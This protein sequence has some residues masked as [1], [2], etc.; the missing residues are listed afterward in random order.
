MYISVVIPLYNKK[1]AIKDALDSVFNQTFLPDE[2]VI[3]NDGSTDGSEKIVELLNHPLVTLIHQKNAGVSAARNKGI[4]TAKNEWIAFLDADD[5]WM[6]NY[7]KEITDLLPSFPES[8]VLAT[9][10]AL[11]DSSGNR[12]PIILNK[13]PFEGQRGVLTN[14]FQVAAC[15][16][17]PLWSSAIV[18][19]KSA[20]QAVGGFP[21]GIKSGE[22][23]LTWARLAV[24]FQIG[25][26]L[27]VNSVFIQDPAHTYDDKPNRIPEVE[28]I[29]G[30]ELIKLYHLN[31][32]AYFL[33]KYISFWKKMRSSIYLRLGE[34]KRAFTESL[35]AL[36][37]NPFNK[38]VYVYVVMTI[39]PM[40]IVHSIFKKYGG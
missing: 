30:D 24:K 19:K 18:V 34:R 23:L 29:V 17:P 8:S 11:Q 37:Y 38:V 20:L 32:N 13:L 27:S 33:K 21:V 15:S 2:I 5:V 22:D 3:I 25:Y 7:L 36:F 26:S 12:S 28:D 40:K 4:N 1:N 10:Y 35:K 9:A 39:L 31:P 14:Y 16:H 6:P